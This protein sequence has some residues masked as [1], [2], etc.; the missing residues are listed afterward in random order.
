MI[1]TEIF[2]KRHDGEELVRTY[3]DTGH[4]I[5]KVGTNE[6]YDE[7]IDLESASYEYEETGWPVVILEENTGEEGD[8]Q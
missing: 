6:V 2:G 7:A 1:K 5:R 8:K 4:M 3:S